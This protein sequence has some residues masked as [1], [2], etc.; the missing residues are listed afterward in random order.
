[1][2]PRVIGYSRRMRLPST[3]PQPAVASAGSICSALVSASFM[4]AVLQ[5]PAESVVQQGF[6][7]FVEGGQLLLIKGFRA[8]GFKNQSGQLIDNGLLLLHGRQWDRDIL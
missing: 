6:L 8:L 1:M 3:T 2:R 7:Q 4:G 5:L